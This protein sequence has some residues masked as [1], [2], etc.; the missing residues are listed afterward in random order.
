M[1]VKVRKIANGFMHV[2]D[3][4]FM[5]ESEIEEAHFQPAIM[6]ELPLID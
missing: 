1:L 5:S 6:P 4:Q 2:A 3:G